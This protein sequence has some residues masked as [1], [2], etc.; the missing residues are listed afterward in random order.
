MKFEILSKGSQGQFCQT[1]D[2]LCKLA[3]ETSNCGWDLIDWRSCRKVAVIEF[4][5]ICSS[6]VQRFTLKH[7]CGMIIFPLGE[8][9]MYGQRFTLKDI[10]GMVIFP[11][12]EAVMYVWISVLLFWLLGLFKFLLWA[13]WFALS[14]GQTVTYVLKFSDM[15][16]GHSAYLLH[17]VWYSVVDVMR[18]CN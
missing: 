12:G 4:V 6:F 18:E 1:I 11:K 16:L 13:H 17:G 15:W 8:L 14:L 7:I 9:V 2:L 10:C 5:L 3:G